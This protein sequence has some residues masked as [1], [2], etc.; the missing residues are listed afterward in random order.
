MRG[1]AK[2]PPA[3]SKQPK[4]WAHLSA[5]NGLQRMQVLHR[6]QAGMDINRD[7]SSVRPDRLDVPSL[8]GKGA[9]RAWPTL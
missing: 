9:R 5:Q 2:V 4:S 6:L 1:T 7:V 3:I 8:F